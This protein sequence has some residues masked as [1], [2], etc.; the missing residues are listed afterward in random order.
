MLKLK[1]KANSELK[2]TQKVWQGPDFKKKLPK[3]SL[4]VK[5]TKE[6]A[7]NPYPDYEL[8]SFICT[9]DELQCFREVYH[10]SRMLYKQFYH[11]N[12]FWLD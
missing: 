11:Q 1:P 5:K 10:L 9:K 8:I 4:Q 7:E 6:D 2:L 3:L 12:Q